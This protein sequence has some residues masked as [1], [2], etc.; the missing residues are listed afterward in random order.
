MNI[1][2]RRSWFACLVVFASFL[3]SCS[4]NDTANGT[5]SNA[6]ETELASISFV[7]ESGQ[8]LSRAVARTWSLSEQ[9]TEI[10]QTD[11]LDK[12]PCPYQQAA[13]THRAVLEHLVVQF[14]HAKLAASHVDCACVNLFL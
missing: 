13:E 7:T 6:G 11:T 5:G 3:T 12:V 4:N 1:F 8:P 9:G 2:L 14:H 10:V